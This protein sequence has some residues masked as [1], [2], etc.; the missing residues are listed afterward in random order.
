MQYIFEPRLKTDSNY[1][2]ENLINFWD[3]DTKKISLIIK[4]INLE[5]KDK[6]LTKE[7]KKSKKNFKSPLLNKKTIIENK[8]MNKTKEV[9]TKALIQKK[10]QNQ[11]HLQVIPIIIIKI[12]LFM[13]MINTTLHE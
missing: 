11:V 9:E 5:D 2:K 6:I 10:N 8:E 1:I 3:E 4:S 12:F 7:T 13:M